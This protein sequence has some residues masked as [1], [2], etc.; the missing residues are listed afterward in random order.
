MATS[1]IVYTPRQTGTN[2]NIQ[3]YRVE[4]RADGKDFTEVKSGDLKV[5]GTDPITIPF[6]KPENVTAVKLVWVKATN[7]NAAAAE[8]A[9]LDANAAPDFES[10][11]MLIEAAK[12]IKQ[13]GSCKHD[14]F[15][16]APSP[17]T[18]RRT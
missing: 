6:D 18:S 5:A 14:I 3:K 17:S 2:G 11:R 16:Q 7:G 4:V 10:L 15:T 9:L 13:D 8:L 1:G 12:T